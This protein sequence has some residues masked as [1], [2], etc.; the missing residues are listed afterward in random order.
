MHSV[1]NYAP[2]FREVNSARCRDEND[3]HSIFFETKA[4]VAYSHIQTK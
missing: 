4:V 1:D 3:L 2:A